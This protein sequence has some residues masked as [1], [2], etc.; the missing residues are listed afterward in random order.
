MNNLLL[1]LRKSHN[2]HKD[3]VAAQ[4]DLSIPEYDLIE[5]GQTKLNLKQAERLAELYNIESS[6]LLADNAP[7][8]N[9][10]IGT[11]SRGITNVQN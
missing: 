4:L 3:Q 8:V 1:L 10:N 5:H 11:Y 2:F 7:V 9:Y 6:H